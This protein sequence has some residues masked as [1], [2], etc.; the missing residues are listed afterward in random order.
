MARAMN[1]L[2]ASA[3]R[4]APASWSRDTR[5]TL[6]MLALIGWTIAPHLLRL[7]PWLGLLSA[8]VL[9]WRAVLAIRQRPLP[10][11]GVLVAVLILSAGLAWWSQRSLFGKDASV[12]LLVV[13]M[14]LKTLELRARRDALVVFF[15][16]FFLILTNFLYS[17]SLLTAL[18]MALSVWGWLTA[19][20]L[21][22]I[23]A[24]RPPL[25][26]AS[27]L[28]ARAALV[29][30]PVM[31]VL[32]LLFP[33][34]GPLWSL[35]DEGGRSGL[36]DE[37]KLGEVAELA[38]DDSIALR[39]K[40]DGPVPPP[41]QLYFRGPVLSHYDGSRWTVPPNQTMLLSTSRM[42]GQRSRD[43]SIEGSGS[44]L[45]YEMTLEPQHSAWLPLLEITPDRPGIPPPFDYLF[46]DGEGQW[47]LRLPLS[48]RVRF[49]AKA[50]PA[51]Q[52][53][54]GLPEAEQAELTRLP[55]GRHPRTR[56][57]AAAWRSQ[58]GL[59]N[60]DPRALSNAL[61]Q[62]IRTGGFSYTLAPGRYDGDS[63]DEFWLD[64]REGFCEHFSAAYVVVMRALGVPARI[65]TGYQGSDP[66]LTDGYIV[67]RQSHAHAWAEFWTPDRGWQRADPTGAVAPERV[68][69]S[70]ALQGQP[71]LMA[72]ALDAVTPG[73]RLQLRQWLETL[74]NRW[75]QTVLGY[76]RQQQFKLLDK[77]G[78]PSVDLTALGQVLGGLLA[79]VALGGALWAAWDARRRTP[80]QRLQR[81]MQDEMARLGV[82]A[83]PQLP[84]GGLAAQVLRVHGP[85][86]QPVA[87]A[88]KTLEAL[89]Y[90]RPTVGGKPRPRDNWGAW[91]REF[92]QRCATLRRALARP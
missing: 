2:S 34:I 57:W 28:A 55:R 90:G 62:H 68:N 65:V 63:I 15:L 75:N 79:T 17:Q 29:G 43:Q 5:D 60:A 51:A 50:W 92:R 32:F 91:R 11:R 16:G 6:F 1:T 39:L 66:E 40:V 58:A 76:G 70:R 46:T 18:A 13:L 61:L 24:G 23:P 83:P 69:R 85:A 82:D 12:T 53:G 20:T 73:L 59:G 30:M 9:A 7:S 21:A 56:A 74:D 25:R 77:L 38:L 71:G 37:L 86:G 3:W 19:L 22:H 27:A 35:P 8:G 81:S 49:Q 10:S 33:R 89:R 41:S 26:E 72:G 78:M 87:D 4:G 47:R 84:P 14:A 80:W 44:P 64:R 67:V 52:I 45:P 36:S 48:E 88:L 42:P 54:S 31:L